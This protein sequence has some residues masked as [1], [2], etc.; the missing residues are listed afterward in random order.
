MLVSVAYAP[1]LLSLLRPEGELGWPRVPLG[2][3]A[4]FLWAVSE[5]R[6]GA[7]LPLIPELDLAANQVAQMLAPETHQSLALAMAVVLDH[8]AAH[9]LPDEVAEPLARELLMLEGRRP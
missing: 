1:L 3:L 4:R 5:A 9:G 2:V 8:L 7:A 6:T